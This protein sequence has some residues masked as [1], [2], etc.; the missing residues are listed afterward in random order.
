MTYYGA[1]ELADSFRT[2]R[3][4]TIRVAEDIPQNKYSFA[5][6]SDL[7]SVEKLLTHIAVASRFHYQIHAIDRLSTLEG[8]NF[9]ALMQQVMAEEA[10]SR[11]K[12]EIIELLGKEG[13]AWANFVAGLPEDSLSQVI[14]MPKGGT[15]P[16][17][18]RFD[19]ILSVKEHE[20]HHRGQLM[21]IDRMI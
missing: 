13:E 11:T 6:A 10:K 21:T 4:N 5:A 14:T 19:M 7:R 2:V 18:T 3:K 1:K 20:M 9:S 8:F 17:R 16:S 15:P 12:A